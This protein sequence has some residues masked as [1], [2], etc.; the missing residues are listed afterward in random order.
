MPQGAKNSFLNIVKTRNIDKVYE[1]I[2]EIIS[3]IDI[4]HASAT[5]YRDKTYVFDKLESSIGANAL[6]IFLKDVFRSALLTVGQIKL[7]HTQ[8]HTFGHQRIELFNQLLQRAN[9]LPQEKFAQRI[10]IK[11]AVALMRLRTHDGSMNV[12]VGTPR[13]RHTNSIGEKWMELEG[14]IAEAEKYYGESARICADLRSV[15]PMTINSTKRMTMEDDIESGENGS[16]E[17]SDTKRQKT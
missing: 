8:E 1:D 6:N 10:E 5:M 16:G 12:S 9:A 15:L 7:T 2:E 11:R 13:F 14:V 17:S 3:R 4:K